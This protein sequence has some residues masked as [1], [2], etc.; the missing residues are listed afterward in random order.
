MTP[1]QIEKERLKFE[2]WQREV[3]KALGMPNPDDL[4]AQWDGTTYGIHYMAA[5]WEGWRARAA[6]AAGDEVM[7]NAC[8][9]D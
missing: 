6:L 7:V 1:D 5:M 8:G 3:S 2:S 9:E 4:L